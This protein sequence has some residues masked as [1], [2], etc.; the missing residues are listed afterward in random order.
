[1]VYIGTYP[2]SFLDFFTLSRE[3]RQTAATNGVLPSGTKLS[4]RARKL[5][6]AATNIPNG[7]STGKSNENDIPLHILQPKK[8]ETK[9]DGK[10]DKRFYNLTNTPF[11]D[12]SLVANGI[13]PPP[14]PPPPSTLMTGTTY[15][16]PPPPPPPQHDIHEPHHPDDDDEE[17]RDSTPTLPT[18]PDH[19]PHLSKTKA[20]FVTIWLNDLLR[21]DPAALEVYWHSD[22]QQAQRDDVEEAESSS[23]VVPPDLVP[24]LSTTGETASST[25]SPTS[26]FGDELF[27]TAETVWPRRKSFAP[28]ASVASIET[29]VLPPPAID[30]RDPWRGGFASIGGKVRLSRVSSLGCG[31]VREEWGRLLFAKEGEEEEEEGEV[32]NVKMVGFEEPVVG[33]TEGRN[34]CG[35]PHFQA[36]GPDASLRFGLARGAGHF[37]TPAAGRNVRE[38]SLSV[39]NVIDNNNISD[40]IFTINNTTLHSESSRKPGLRAEPRPDPSQAQPQAQPQEQGAASKQWNLPTGFASTGNSSHTQSFEEIYGIPEN[41]LEIEVTDPQTHQPTSSP[42]SRYTTYLIRLSTNIPAFK[43]RRSEV[44]RRYSDFEVFRDL[45]ERE[46][47]RVSIPPLPGKVYLNRF[48]DAVIEERRRG[49]ER[50]L[51]IVVG[52]P[53]LQTG[54]RVLGS[55][56]QDPS[57]DRNSW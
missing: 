33:S 2:I 21:H 30:F 43:L 18:L 13:T 35:R 4:K 6:K 19:K 52:H 51:K 46:S 32:V 16:E 50:F 40:T 29:L 57:W 41:F 34:E 45:L 3:K 36:H 17:Q 27:R 39:Y 48:D 44:R 49:L 56:V 55:F 20:A 22:F 7:N 12:F 15:I 31:G 5:N 11:S 8:I 42:S 26:S 53:L 24:D 47:A 37:G 23:L 25:C 9:N 54:S 10:R 1:M 38:V 14:P 28:A